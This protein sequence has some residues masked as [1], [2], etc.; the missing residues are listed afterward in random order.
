MSRALT[1]L[2]AL[3]VLT[4][5]ALCVVQWQRD[6]RL[7]IDLTALQQTNQIQFASIV[8]QSNALRGVNED[9]AQFK[10]RFTQAHSDVTETRASLRKLEGENEQLL[11]ERNQLKA[12]VTNWASAVAERDERLKEITARAQELAMKLNDSVLRF[13]ELATNYNVSA[14]RFDALATNYNKVVEELNQL[15]S[16]GKKPQSPSAAK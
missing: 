13:N 14:R 12:S 6:R 1:I 10:Q 7:H 16:A 3:G 9:L 11:A 15:R 5:A 2:N 8:E 4:L